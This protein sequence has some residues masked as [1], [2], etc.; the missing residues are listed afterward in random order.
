MRARPISAQKKM[1]TTPKI[2]APMHARTTPD[3]LVWTVPLSPLQA[4]S[5]RLQLDQTGKKVAGF[6]RFLLWE[7]FLLAEGT[8][9]QRPSVV[10]RH[11][12]VLQIILFHILFWSS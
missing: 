9:R 6:R 2:S 10:V 3:V 4:S 12:T 7:R 1:N 8:S 11:V 5:W